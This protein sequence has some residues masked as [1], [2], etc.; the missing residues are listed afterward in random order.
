MRKQILPEDPVPAYSY[1]VLH[2]SAWG[3][4]YSEA[5]A[6]EV[7]G[8]VV[9]VALS[10]TLPSSIEVGEPRRIWVRLKSRPMLLRYGFRLS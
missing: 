2:R 8:R 9:I 4:C 10:L 1:L 6:D 3:C 7:L 5:G